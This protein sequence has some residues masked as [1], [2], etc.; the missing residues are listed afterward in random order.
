MYGEMEYHDDTKKRTMILIIIVSALTLSSLGLP[1][2]RQ[3]WLLKTRQPTKPLRTVSVKATHRC[4][5]LSITS[6][7]DKNHD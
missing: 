7:Q 4:P 6:P 5:E 1:E 2:R 3:L